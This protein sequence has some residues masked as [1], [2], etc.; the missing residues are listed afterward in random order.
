MPVEATETI[1]GTEQELPQPQA[2]TGSGT[3]SDSCE[4]VAELEEQDSTQTAT[5]QVQW[6][7]QLK[8]MKNQVTIQ[9]SKNILFV[10]T[11]PDVYKTTAS[12]TYLI[13]GEAKIEDLSQQAQLE[14]A[15]KFK[16]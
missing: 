15:E 7:Q 13:F 16:V 3:E 8:S 10:I 14:A 1:T 11:K 5:Q 6:Q 12:D 4:S 2:E 9:T